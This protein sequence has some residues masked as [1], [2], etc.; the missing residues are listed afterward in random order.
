MSLI[1]D[2]F[3]IQVRGTAISIYYFGI[4]IGYSLAFA[5]GSGIEKV[6]NWR[7]VFFLS[8]LAG[9]LLNNFQISSPPPPSGAPPCMCANPLPLPS[10]SSGIAVVPFVLFTVKEPKRTKN[11][12][13]DTAD[14]QKKLPFA[15]RLLFLL[16]TFAMPGMLT[17]CIAGGVRNAGGYV[18]AYNTEIFF[19][20][21]G[22]TSD[23]IKSFM[24]WIPLVAGSIGAVVGGVISDVLVKGRGPYMRIW[25]LIISQVR[26]WGSRN[27]VWEGKGVGL[28]LKGSW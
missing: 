6:L 18:W 22:Y 27:V 16:R 10:P 13:V 24:S 3:A 7:W 8:A 2:Y 14:Q 20:K 4:Y 5:I 21:S 1:G 19:E 23:H 25:V 17:L 9:E 11:T 26:G 28:N 15:R 12:L